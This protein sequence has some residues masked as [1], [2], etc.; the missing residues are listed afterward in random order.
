MS[1]VSV[2]VALAVAATL[3]AGC[4]S[5]D[6]GKDDQGSNAG[7]S[8]E[9]LPFDTELR[10]GE[11]PNTTGCLEG[12]PIG[13][14]FS[15]EDDGEKWTIKYADSTVQRG[16]NEDVDNPE[17]VQV[18]FKIEYTLVKSADGPVEIDEVSPFQM[19]A[20]GDRG[21]LA[22]CGQEP[23]S[24]T[25]DVGGSATVNYCF[26]KAGAHSLV[27]GPF[28]GTLGRFNSLGDSQKGQAYL[29]VK[30]VASPTEDES[31]GSEGTETQPGLE[32]GEGSP[33]IP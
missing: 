16:V 29:A 10:C 6:G 19:T 5:G 31:G 2:A 20:L 9:V 17:R 23:A 13:T 12:A 15:I 27:A 14:T 25:L 30:D 26:S 11:D 4:G 7:A 8:S 22:E 21:G 28:R 18:D 24:A 33:P 1:R 3:V 32:E